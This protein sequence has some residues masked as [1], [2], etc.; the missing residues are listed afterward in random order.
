[1]ILYTALPFAVLFLAPSINSRIV[2]SNRRRQWNDLFW[3]LSA[4]AITLIFIYGLRDSGGADDAAYRLYYEHNLG[5][6]FL[7]FFEAE[8]EP[9]FNLIKLVGYALGLNYKGL[10]LGYAVI[11]I[12]FMIAGLKNHYERKSDVTLYIAAFFFI[13]F[14][15]VMTVMRQAAAMAMLFYLYSLRKP[16]WKQR[17]L[18]WFLILCTHYGFVILLPV[19]IAMVC[20]KH[21]LSTTIKILVPLGCLV[22]GQ[23]VNLNEV[24]RIITS[25]LGLY[26]YMNDDVNYTD[27]S[28]IGIVTVIL[29]VLY[30]VMLLYRK[31]SA[32]ASVQLQWLD[33]LDYSLMMYF[34]LLLLAANLHWA[35]RLG[36]FYTCM[37]P[38]LITEC[39]NML[40]IKKAKKFPFYAVVLCLYGLFLVYMHGNYGEAG[41]QWSVGFWK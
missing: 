6:S 37:V 36:M 33:K 12:A 16:T 3:I 21:R 23:T 18:M 41:Y 14:P 31:R 11:I 5:G 19:E 8:K 24:I 39:F 7:D 17:I 30:I 13:A 15:A 4:F 10:F 35:N 34:S 28:G 1:M 26:G 38:H 25:T 20:I 27:A 22:I 32:Y 40:P 9:V 2:I 29:F